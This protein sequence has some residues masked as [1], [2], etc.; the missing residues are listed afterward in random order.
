MH[1]KGKPIDIFTVGDRVTAKKLAGKVGGRDYL[2]E[3]IFLLLF[4]EPTVLEVEVGDHLFLLI[5]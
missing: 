1:D 4:H 2:E 5:S 3:L